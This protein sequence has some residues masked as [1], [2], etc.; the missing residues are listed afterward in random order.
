MVAPRFTIF[1]FISRLAYL[2]TR[3]GFLQV[4]AIVLIIALVL[5]RLLYL[6]IALFALFS[7]ICALGQALCLVLVGLAVEFAQLFLLSTVGFCGVR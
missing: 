4:A 7:R 3:P 1:L 2:I 5:A 6:L